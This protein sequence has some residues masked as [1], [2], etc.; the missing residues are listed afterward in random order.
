MQQ[1]IWCPVTLQSPFAEENRDEIKEIIPYYAAQQLSQQL[2]VADSAIPQGS[3][4]N[5]KCPEDCS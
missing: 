2:P 5:T 4:I 1:G 3:L